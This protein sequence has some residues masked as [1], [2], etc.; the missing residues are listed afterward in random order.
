VLYTDGLIE[1]RQ[2][3]IDVG[4][5]AMLKVLGE[6]HLRPQGPPHAAPALDTICDCLVD[7]LLPERAGD[8]A[9]LL[10]A[11]TRALAADRIATWDLPPEPAVVAEA[12]ARTVR[13][14][15]AWGLSELAFTTELLV[16]ELVTNAIRHA[17]PPIQLRLLLDGVL[18]CGVSDGG[19]TAP[20]LRRADRYDE[21]G[22]G[23][24]LVA[25]LAERW[26]T[27]HTRTGKTIW[28]Q[29]PLPRR[30]KVTAYEL[31]D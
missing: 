7:A 10:V 30:P 13:Q 31:E 6:V 25:Q 14:L 16:S 5:N 1:S 23:L 27:R 24:M 26:G 4:L 22:R 11:R 12:R 19:S 2:R 28:A 3:D 20:H 18:S 9:A 8:D 29:Q 15:A 17:Q 21:G